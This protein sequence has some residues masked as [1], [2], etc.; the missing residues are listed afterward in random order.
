M[1]DSFKCGRS[2]SSPLPAAAQRGYKFREADGEFM[3]HEY[4]E[5]DSQAKRED[6]VA[7]LQ[8]TS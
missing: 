3:L 6:M 5:Q 4:A 7:E 8:D 2:E 1:Q